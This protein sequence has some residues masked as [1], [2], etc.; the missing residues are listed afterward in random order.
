M[1]VHF[2]SGTSKY[3]KINNY[4][5]KKSSIVKV[6]RE[7]VIPFCAFF[8]FILDEISG[9]PLVTCMLFDYFARFLSF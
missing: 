3:C 4:F 2:P 6:L 7:L 5:R 9:A 8:H 1:N